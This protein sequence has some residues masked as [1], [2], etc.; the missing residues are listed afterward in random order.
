M[1]PGARP[2]HLQEAQAGHRAALRHDHVTAL[3][4]Y[5]EAMRIAVESRAP[6][7]FFRHYLEASLESLELLEA[8]DNV[9]A[10]CEK[11]IQFYADN[12]P[13]NDIHWHDLASIH[14][15]RAI[16]LLKSDRRSDALQAFQEA[17]RIADRIPAPLPLAR[18]VLGW[19]DRGLF[20]TRERLLTEQRRLRYFSVSADWVEVQAAEGSPPLTRS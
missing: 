13:K 1:T 6:E 3:R 19:L 11:A 12:P 10:Y 2:R 4:H 16:S 17:L 15:R 5:R 18:L 7:I 20:V 9:L 8:Y 14:Q